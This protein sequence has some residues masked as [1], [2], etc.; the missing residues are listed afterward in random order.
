LDDDSKGNCSLTVASIVDEID[1]IKYPT[2]YEVPT[3]NY[4]NSPDYIWYVL[5]RFTSNT[6]DGMIS[7][8]S[9]DAFHILVGVPTNTTQRDLRGRSS[10]ILR[11]TGKSYNG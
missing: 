6:N 1:Q 2:L 7:N 3:T 10:S 5:S 4:R 11:P 8:G 9:D